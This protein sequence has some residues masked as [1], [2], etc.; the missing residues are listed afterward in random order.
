MRKLVHVALCLAFASACTTIS[1]TATE[2][3]E[4]PVNCA[5]AENDIDVL[6]NEKA[7]VAKQV[8]SGVRMVIPAA[9]VLGILRRD[10]GNRAEV[11]TGA[12][13]DEIE[14]KISEIR[15]TCGLPA[16]VESE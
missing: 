5:T 16:P 3:L 6:E 4:K 14:A 11:A 12:Y 13:N 1:D 15:S 9:L 8:A 7:S 10:I 2:Q